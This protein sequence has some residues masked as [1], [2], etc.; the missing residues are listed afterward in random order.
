MS[1]NDMSSW[2]FKFMSPSLT[3]ILKKLKPTGIRNQ[4]I[5]SHTVETNERSHLLTLTLPRISYF[6]LHCG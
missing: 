1:G 2:F 4:Y 5:S 3:V 6:S